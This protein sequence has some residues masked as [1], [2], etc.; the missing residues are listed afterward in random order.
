MSNKSLFLGHLIL[1]VLLQQPKLTKTRILIANMSTTTCADFQ[2]NVHLLGMVSQYITGYPVVVPTR[3]RG[4]FLVACSFGR[5]QAIDLS[6]VQ[7]CPMFL[8]Y[9]GAA[10]LAEGSLCNLLFSMQ[11]H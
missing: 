11:A 9:G 2:E 6:K 3:L 7:G 4:G 10:G 5:G 1:G 8:W